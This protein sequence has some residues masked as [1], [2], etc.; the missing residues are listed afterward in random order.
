MKKA[1]NFNPGKWLVENK[2]TKQSRLNE[3][4]EINKKYYAVYNILGDYGDG[5]PSTLT[6]DT[7]EDM[8]DKLNKTYLELTGEKRAPYSIE[9]FDDNNRMYMGKKLPHFISDDWA[10]VTDD[11]QIF[12]QDIDNLK[13]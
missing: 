10:S 6:A 13:K 12:K 4:T 9:D 2:I 1:D 3:A 8:L 5:T 7:K 11:E